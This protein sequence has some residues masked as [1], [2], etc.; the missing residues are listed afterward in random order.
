[1]DTLNKKAVSPLLV[2]IAFA[3]VY[4]VWGSTYFFIQKAIVDFP[5]FIL[6]A[7]RFLIAGVLMLAWTG[8][9][10]EPVFVKKD[11]IR[12]AISGVLMLFVGTGAVIWVEQYLPSA[13]VAI[14]VSAAPLWFT[15]LDKPKWS[16]NFRN[17]FTIGGLVVGF[18]GVMLLFYEKIVDAF[19]GNGNHTELGAVGILII[20]SIAWTV[21]SLYSKYKPTTG[22]VSVNIGWQMLAAGI[23][24]IPGC[25][26]RN[27]FEVV[28]WRS[29]SLESWLSV[30]YLIVLGSI[31][32]FSAYVWL[33]QVRPSTQVSTYAYVNP[34]VAILLGVFFAHEQITVFQVVGLVIILGSV[35][36][37]NFVKGKNG[38]GQVKKPFLTNKSNVQNQYEDALIHK[39]GA[40]KDIK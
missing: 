21:G 8:W 26:L 6:G 2:I 34:V 4:I 30:A 18:A 40:L 36:M 17:K 3:T 38:V 33:L 10:G 27:E 29:I 7:I 31:A 13:M 28:Q 19:S 20:G 11:I 23:A 35:L 14:M 15:L 39:R 25:F 22:S 12:A 37:I 16:E 24:F 32:A 5:P 9:R 1:M